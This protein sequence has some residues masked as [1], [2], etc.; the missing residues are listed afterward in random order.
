MM[1]WICRSF[2]SA[3]S[4]ATDSRW[5]SIRR[6]WMALSTAL[7][8]MAAEHWAH[9]GAGPHPGPAPGGVG[10]ERGVAHGLARAATIRSC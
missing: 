2:L 6:S 4:N 5:C 1:N 10:A 3:A 7:L 8:E 9:R